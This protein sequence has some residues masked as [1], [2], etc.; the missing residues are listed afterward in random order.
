LTG[1]I[2]PLTSQSNRWRIAASRCLTE[3]AA[4]SRVAA[5]IH[6]ATCRLYGSD[7]GYADA[8][9]P[10]QKFFRSPVIGPPRVRIADVG[11]KEFEE[12]DGRAL[13]GGGDK[14]VATR[15]SRSRRVGS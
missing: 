10:G 13:A 5:S 9:A 6:V 7:R 11:G 4:S 14:R 12:A 1:T 15:A 2:W 3:G 8:H